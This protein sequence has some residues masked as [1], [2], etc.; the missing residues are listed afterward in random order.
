[1]R[2]RLTR[3]PPWSLLQVTSLELS[4]ACHGPRFR[5]Q[6]S[7][8]LTH[9]APRPSRMA[10]FLLLSAGAVTL[11]SASSPQL[12]QACAFT[13]KTLMAVTRAPPRRRPVALL[14]RI[15]PAHAQQQY[16]RPMLPAPKKWAA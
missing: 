8:I 2:N 14:A 15:L 5:A 7:V 16:K 13:V 6:T 10:L 3:T 9:A 4:S 1:M 12:P 11:A